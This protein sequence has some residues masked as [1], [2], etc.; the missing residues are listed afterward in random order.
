[1]DL[2]YDLIL[3]TELTP[4]RYGAEYAAYEDGARD[5][6]NLLHRL[7]KIPY[8]DL[9]WCFKD[10]ALWAQDE[11]YIQESKSVSDAAGWADEE[12][13]VS[14][15]D[16]GMKT[17]GS[18][19]V[20][21]GFDYSW[22]ATGTRMNGQI[23]RP[24]PHYG[25][26]LDHLITLVDAVTR[27]QRPQHLAFGP[28][29]YLVHHHPLDRAR[30]GIR[31]IGWI[32]FAIAPAELLEAEIVRPMNG[33]TLIVTQSR[34]WQ[35][36]ERHPDYSAQAIRRAQNVELRLNALGLLPTAPDIMRGDWG[37]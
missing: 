17:L 15:I 28:S 7:E 27:W 13:S 11:A 20:Y 9:G 31:W 16:N 24:H 30:L 21:Y 6:F 34:L 2:T 18:E 35:V 8:F 19:K 23:K 33:G 4:H 12:G 5:F 26:Q 10:I 22:G 1:M 14:T 29:G 32:P 37:R 3:S 25:L 36:G